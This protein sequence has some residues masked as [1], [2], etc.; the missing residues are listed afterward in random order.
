MTT[1]NNIKKTPQTTQMRQS[2]QKTQTEL[3]FIQHPKIT[4]NYDFLIYHFS[5]SI[6]YFNF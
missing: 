6:F 2:K 5:K 4:E 1:K 3:Q